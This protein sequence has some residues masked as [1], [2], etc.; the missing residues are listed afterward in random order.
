MRDLTTIMTGL[1][2]EPSSHRERS[3]NHYRKRGIS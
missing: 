2:F 3:V 1:M